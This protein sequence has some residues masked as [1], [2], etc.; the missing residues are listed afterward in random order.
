ME[1]FQICIRLPTCS[2]LHLAVLSSTTIGEIKVKV[3]REVGTAENRL[4]LTYLEGVLKDWERVN[5]VGIGVNCVLEA[6]YDQKR[7]LS[8]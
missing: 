8:P 1:T 3:G 4:R 6:Y 5:T 7:G 2:Q